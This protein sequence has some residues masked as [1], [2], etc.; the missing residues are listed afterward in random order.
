MCTTYQQYH[1]NTNGSGSKKAYT[2]DKP[3]ITHDEPGDRISSIRPQQN[4]MCYYSSMST[5]G[6]S[7][8]S[9]VINR[10]QRML[11]QFA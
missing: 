2:L 11:L 3:D 9:F 10:P 6:F 1:Y 4:Q 8:L 5:T 7:L